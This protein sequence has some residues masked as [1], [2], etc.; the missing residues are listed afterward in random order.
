MCPGLRLVGEERSGHVSCPI[1]GD[2]DQTEEAWEPQIHPFSRGSHL[3]GPVYPKDV[4][5]IGD[6]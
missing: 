1:P 4:G 6:F 5:R 2:Q 3:L